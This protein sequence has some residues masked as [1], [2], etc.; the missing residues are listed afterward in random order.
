M[1][2]AH[3]N[4]IGEAHKT[5]D[6]VKKRAI[7]IYPLVWICVLTATILYQIAPT[8][9]KAV[10]HNPVNIIESLAL[11][12]RNPLDAVDFPSWTL[13]HE[14]IFYV[15]C[16]IIIFKPKLGFPLFMIWSLVCFI[17]NFIGISEAA[18]PYPLQPINCLFALGVACAF[19]ASRFTIRFPLVLMIVGIVA[20]FAFGLSCDYLRIPDTLQHGVYGVASALIILGGVE[21]DRSQRLRLPKWTLAAGTLSYPLYLTHMITL[22]VLAKLMVGT[23]ATR[24]LPPLVGL[25]IFVVGTVLAA[26]AVHLAIE[27]PVT[28]FLKRRL[29]DRP[30]ASALRAARQN[31]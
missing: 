8:A 17:A 7:R 25:G 16:A 5:I 9:G 28:R 13:W 1:I 31:A 10:Y 30:A 15:F 23:H 4:D 12:G 21:L 3:L 2:W 18:T 27:K 19:V 20:F 14:N 22:P 24:V 29:V 6:F 26:F 11:V